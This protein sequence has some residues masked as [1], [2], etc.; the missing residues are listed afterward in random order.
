MR[1]RRI[2]V[3]RRLDTINTQ[4]SGSSGFSPIQSGRPVIQGSGNPLPDEAFVTT[5]TLTIPETPD[6]AQR[7]YVNANEI[8][9]VVLSAPM[10]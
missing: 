1:A 2:Q 4:R 10:P 5:T 8:P 7:H 9:H 6:R 3:V